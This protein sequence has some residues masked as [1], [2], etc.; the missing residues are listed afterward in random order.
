MGL[1]PQA[2]PPSFLFLLFFSSIFF[3]AFFL[4]NHSSLSCPPTMRMLFTGMCG[5]GYDHQKL[6]KKTFLYIYEHP[7]IISDTVQS[8][9]NDSSSYYSSPITSLIVNITVKS[10]QKNYISKH[11]IGL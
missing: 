11:S 2:V 6:P 4:S 8:I 1:C 3:A 7:D 10:N 5:A 9:A